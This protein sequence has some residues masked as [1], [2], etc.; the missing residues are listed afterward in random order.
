[1][2]E[3][4]ETFRFPVC[5]AVVVAAGDSSRMGLGGSKQL[6]SLL[7]VPVLLRTLRALQLSDGIG[8][9]V[10]VCRQADLPEIEPFSR[11]ISKISAIVSGG[12]TRQESVWNGVA[13]VSGKAQY[14][15]IQDGA[16]PLIRPAA[17]NRVV[18]DACRYGVSVLATSVKDTI[19]VSG[20]DGMV[21][22]T[23]ERSTL[24]AVQTPQ[25]F[26][27]DLYLQAA[28]YARENGGEYTDDCQLAE[29]AGISVHLCDGDAT[30]LKITTPEDLVL[31]E[32]ILRAW[33][34]E[35]ADRT[36]I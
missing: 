16:R 36:W 15:A 22:Q 6:L 23:P 3:K 1:M 30:N 24:R 7:G 27:R 11:E 34:E 32:A 18:A 19:K 4:K 8:E 25:V 35:Y 9:I 21:L 12:K 29:R 20:A 33:G 31:A 17:V 10:V 13:A 26:R 2:E 14:L 28:K 5:S